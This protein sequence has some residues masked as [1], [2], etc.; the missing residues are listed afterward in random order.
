METVLS[1]LGTLKTS[2]VAMLP[3][4]GPLPDPAPLAPPGFSNAAGVAIG[5]AK[6]AGLVV[7][8]LSLIVGVCAWAWKNHQ[9]D[10]NSE[11]G[12]KAIVIFVA[13]I[14]VSTAS[15]LVGWLMSA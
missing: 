6:W 10:S 9:G 15:T 13:V 8:V 7:L 12:T 11:F 4:D 14:V 2:L 5:V 1:T 3:W